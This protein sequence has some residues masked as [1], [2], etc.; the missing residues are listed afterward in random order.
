MR[1]EEL[2]SYLQSCGWKSTTA[3]ALAR[4][5]NV[6]CEMSLSKW[7]DSFIGAFCSDHPDS[8]HIVRYMAEAI[9]KDVFDWEDITAQTMRTVRN[10]LSTNVTVNSAKTYLGYIKGTANLNQDKT[11]LNTAQLTSATR[12]KQTP[13]QHI[14][15]TEEELELIHR[16]QPHSKTEADVKRDFMIE[17]Y[18]GARNS[19]AKCLTENNVDGDWITYVSKKTKTKT[20]VPLHRNLLGYLRQPQHKEHSR[21]VVIEV[22]QRICMKCGIDEMVELFAGGCMQRRPKWQFVGSHTARRSFA[23]Q[24]ALRGVAVP[25]IANFMGHASAEMTMRYICIQQNDISQDVKAFF[26]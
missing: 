7:R 23:T 18:C 8:G 4:S 24:L 6:D 21:K 9:G 13:T 1:K 11:G 16:Y 10:Y 14:A 3:Y 25:V 2:V 20:S 5:S 17:A 12:T 19:D 15:L 26:S 22:I